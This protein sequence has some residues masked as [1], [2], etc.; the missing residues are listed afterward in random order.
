MIVAASAKYPLTVQGKQIL[1]LDT[2][3]LL[4]LKWPNWIPS[5][6]DDRQKDAQ[7]LS[8]LSGAGLISRE[9]AVK[10]LAS[11]Y[12]VEDVGKEIGRI[13]ADTMD[14]CEEA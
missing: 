7:T 6:A 11:V 5:T 4:S 2:S 14:N 13:Q 8:M 12:D 1:K 10:A 3:A 9:T